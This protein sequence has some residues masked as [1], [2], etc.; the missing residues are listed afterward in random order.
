MVR[1]SIQS[2]RN[3]GN[4]TRTLSEA[5]ARELAKLHEQLMQVYATRPETAIPGGSPFGQ[6]FSIHQTEWRDAF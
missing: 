6:F 5:T 1:E 4:V 3:V 2:D